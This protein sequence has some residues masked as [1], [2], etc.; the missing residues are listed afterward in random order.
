MDSS[1]FVYECN[2][3]GRAIDARHEEPDDHGADCHIRGVLRR[4]QASDDDGG[5]G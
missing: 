3:C 2:D 5:G 1:A 4:R